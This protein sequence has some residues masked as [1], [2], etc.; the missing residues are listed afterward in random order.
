MW[1]QPSVN[2]QLP[3]IP[4]LILGEEFV[5]SVKITN[6]LTEQKGMLHTKDLR[7][8]S[9]HELYYVRVEAVLRDSALEQLINIINYCRGQ[10]LPVAVKLPFDCDLGHP[11]F[12]HYDPLTGAYLCRYAEFRLDNDGLHQIYRVVRSRDD[13]GV[14]TTSR[15]AALL[16]TVYQLQTFN[17]VP[18]PI[19]VSGMSHNG[20]ITRITNGNNLTTLTPIG[21]FEHTMRLVDGSVEMNMLNVGEQRSQQSSVLLTKSEHIAEVSF[22]LLEV[23]PVPLLPLEEEGGN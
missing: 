16:P 13:F 8:A 23:I 9:A 21:H 4:S 10:S 17:G 11:T 18:A 3:R 1:T 19:S 22:D 20:F 7:P 5:T 6:T 2:T 14:V 12:S 15:K